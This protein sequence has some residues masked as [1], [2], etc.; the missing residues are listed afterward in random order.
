MKTTR[1]SLWQAFLTRLS[2][3]HAPGTKYQPV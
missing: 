3:I 2:R 1:K